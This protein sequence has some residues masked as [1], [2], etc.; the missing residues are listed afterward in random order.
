MG[1]I[2]AITG[3]IGSGKS[4]ASEFLR[5]AGYNVVSCDEITA[6]LYKKRRVKKEI[7]KIFP[8]AVSGK[9]RIRIDKKEVARQVNSAATFESSE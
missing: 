3:G 7:G 1:K 4:L 2:I 5:Q 8:S 6:E 9:C